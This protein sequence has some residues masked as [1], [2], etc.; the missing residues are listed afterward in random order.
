[1]I[2]AAASAIRSRNEVRF[3]ILSAVAGEL[4]P[5]R[6]YYWDGVRWTSAVSPDGVWRWDGSSWRPA[7]EGANRARRS[8]LP[9]LIAGGT[10]VALVAASVGIYFAVGFVMR[11]SQRVL[12][13][14]GPASCSSALAQP[15]AALS[16]G[17]TLCGGKLG[18]E[19]L[20][21]DC[22][23]TDGTPPGVT[24]WKK[25]F[26][27]TEGDWTKTTATTNPD[28]CNLSAPPDVDISFDTA[29]EQ[30]PCERLPER[31]RNHAGGYIAASDLRSCGL[32]HRQPG[33]ARHGNGLAATALRVRISITPLRPDTLKVQGGDS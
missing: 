26:K 17:E 2:L 22:T 14:G 1:F 27:P 15:G 24:V 12:Q 8:R 18:G 19:Y 33:R 28:G 32:L 25:S 20:L 29:D 31:Q 21:A 7:G 30:P 9:W 11:A 4:S 16:E 13:A 10:I 3:C 5:D 23:L 6:L